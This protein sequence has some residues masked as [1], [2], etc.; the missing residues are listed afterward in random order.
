MYRRIEKDSRINIS[1]ITLRSE[2]LRINDGDADAGPSPASGTHLGVSN[3]TRVPHSP[4]FLWSLVAL[5]V[6]RMPDDLDRL[7][8]TSRRLVRKAN[9]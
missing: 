6:E 1:P 4:R 8:L 3:P 5:H 9:T 2:D 7:V